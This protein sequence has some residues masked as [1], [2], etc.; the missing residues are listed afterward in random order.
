[1]QDF[2]DSQSRTREKPS[3]RFFF[4]QFDLFVFIEHLLV[5][6]PE[7]EIEGLADFASRRL[8]TARTHLLERYFQRA[9]NPNL[10]AGPVC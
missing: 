8:E 6:L 3:A 5:T 10:T 1:M 2:S 7:E 4:T 9:N